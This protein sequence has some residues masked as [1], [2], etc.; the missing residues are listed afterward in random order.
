[1]ISSSDTLPDEKVELPLS[2]IGTSTIS[3]ESDSIKV[4]RGDT[5]TLEGELSDHLGN[6][7]SDEEI[8][9]IWDGV[10][11]GTAVTEPDGDFSYEYLVTIDTILGNLNWSANFSGNYFHEG[12]SSSQIT[13]VYQQTVI[14]FD[15]DKT[16]FYAG[17]QFLISGNLS[18]DNGTLFSGTLVFYFD[19]VFIESFIANGSFNF[20]YIPESSYLGC[21]FTFD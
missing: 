4:T 1:M 20:G 2:I 9:I 15:L 3:L 21:R 7:I 18:M 5:I 19:N 14:N 10:V 8:Q 12:S 6:P 11:L 13:E 16:H 17:E